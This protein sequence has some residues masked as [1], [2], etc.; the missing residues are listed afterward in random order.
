MRGKTIV[1]ALALAFVAVAL[2]AVL[3]TAQAEG[4][5][6]LENK[7]TICHRTNSVTNPYE[8]ISVDKSAVDGQGKNDHTHHTGPV[9]TSQQYA[10]ELKDNKTKWGDI[11]PDAANGGVGSGLNWTTE[12]QA[13]YNNECSVPREETAPHTTY[14]LVCDNAKQNAV[15]TFK[16]DGNADS[17]VVL[18]QAQ[19]TLIADSTVE[20]TVHTGANGT[21]IVITIDGAE[22]FNSKVTCAT[23]GSTVTTQ[24]TNPTTKSLP[25]TSAGS[26]ALIAAGIAGTTALGVVLSVIRRSLLATRF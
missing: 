24:G 5:N 10:Q 26:D 20:K 16:N 9:A 1:T 7:V 12:G 23:T 25:N 6:N 3:S 22:V 21:T 15:I 14:N 2:G 19:F 11:I 13:I 18:N 4:D 8:K 17:T